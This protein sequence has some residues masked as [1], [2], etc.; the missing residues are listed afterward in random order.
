MAISRTSVCR[1][2]TLY[3]LQWTF[4]LTCL[5]ALLI[6]VNVLHSVITF[7]DYSECFL[8]LA[9]LTYW[10]QWTVNRSAITSADYS[11]SLLM[12]STRHLL[13]TVNVWRYVETSSGFADYSEHL[14]SRILTVIISP[15]FYFHTHLLITVNLQPLLADYS[16]PFT[17]CSECWTSTL[18]GLL[19]TVN[20]PAIS[21]ATTLLLSLFK[22]IQNRNPLLTT[23]NL[24]PNEH[25]I[26]GAKSY[27]KPEW[28][29]YDRWLQW[30]FALNRS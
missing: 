28:L 26:G 10:L 19:I 13:I 16:E 30:I 15:A 7:T 23:V 1:Q 18:S 6:T 25:K 20:V 9:D 12:K 24:C 17:D 5:P 2:M 3:W 29:N 14:T 22:S 11:E 8:P 4:V 21:A 27:K